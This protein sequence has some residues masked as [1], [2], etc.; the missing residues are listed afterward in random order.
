[1]RSYANST[2]VNSYVRSIPRFSSSTR[3]A[4]TS[5]PSVVR[6]QNDPDNPKIVGSLLV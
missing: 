5:K 3:A 4:S 6:G 2:S 1:M